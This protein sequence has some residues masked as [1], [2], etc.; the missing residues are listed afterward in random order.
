MDSQVDEVLGFV[1]D[2]GLDKI[3]AE[4]LDK[5]A[6]LKQKNYDVY[7]NDAKAYGEELSRREKDY[8]SLVFKMRSELAKGGAK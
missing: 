3:S 7:L 1:A 6:K 2:S 5:F 8:N 4:I